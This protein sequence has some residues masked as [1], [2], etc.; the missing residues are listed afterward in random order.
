[1]AQMALAVSDGG[2]A[3]AYRYFS[4]HGCVF[5]DGSQRLVF[6]GGT[7]VG[8]YDVEDKASR[9]VLLVKLS[10]DSKAHLGRLAWAFELSEEQL[11]RLRRR[12]EA[13]GLSSLVEIKHGGRQRV[14]TPT[15]RRKLYKLFDAGASIDTAHARINKCISRT[16][17]GRVRKVWAGQREHAD[18]VEGKAQQ[19]GTSEPAPVGLRLV[20]PAPAQP[21][22]SAEVAE[23]VACE[24]SPDAVGHSAS[25]AETGRQP[26][27]KAEQLAT[28]RGLPAP[29]S[30]HE[31]EEVATDVAIGSGK[32]YVQHA[33][34]LIML[35]LLNA[36]GLYR[37]AESLRQSA[38]AAGEIE[39]RYLGQTALRVAL[40]ATIIALTI[41]QKCVEGVRRIAT[42]SA[43]AL[44][45]I[46]L[47]VPTPQ[48]V[49]QVVG[50]FAQAR[51]QLLHCAVS[52]ALID[53]AGREPE[54]RA[55]FY[56]DNHL[57]PY[58]GR[59][60]LR[61][62]WRMQDKRVRPGAADY[63]VHDQ[64]GR[65]LLRMGSPSHE[66]MTQQLVPIGRLLRA[67]L[68][69]AGAE[70]TRVTLVF[71]RAGAFPSQL[72]QLRDAGFEFVTYERRPYARLLASE[73]DQ[74]LQLGGEVIRYCEPHQKNLGKGRG[75]IRRIHL[76]MP[77]GEQVNVLAI[78]T[79]PAEDLI[80]ALL[81]RWALQENQFKYGVE[82]L[83]IN[84]LDGRR[85]EL[86]PADEVIPNPARRR[87]LNA[88]AIARKLEGEALRQLA[89]LPPDD[90]RRERWEQELRRSRKQQQDLEAQRPE[91]PERIRVGDSE[92]AGRLSRHRDDYKLVIDTLRVVI[93]NIIA[94]LATTL[95]PH[96]S[97]AAEA[98]KTLDNLL[99]AP[100]VVRVNRNRIDVNL[101]PAATR[102]ERAAF[103][104]L[105]KPI[106]ARKLALPGDPARRPVRFEVHIE[107][108]RQL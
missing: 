82:R 79:A 68:D 57:R 6:V 87:L 94:D 69:H 58:T 21:E 83:G 108:D 74:E 71:D 9:N 7:L 29:P 30:L 44:L 52:F 41:G 62:G 67:G 105:L 22:P 101:L 39:C 91:V 56:A 15:L 1:M 17:V 92:L 73:F 85:V 70:R 96:L 53:E 84:Q 97:R 50:R 23:A 33:G 72:A 47:A 106:N 45:R 66:P 81:A 46:L 61:K 86:V 18:G 55:W 90:R 65:P 76:L 19:V 31:A 103:A 89:H 104:N 36:L 63:W 64:D 75:R 26:P 77:D 88:L 100:A 4:A 95:G 28:A 43:Q 24:A 38:I 107:G 14:V 54:P 34:S 8:S 93:A 35:A 5:K 2:S 20:S 42:P 40:D 3:S 25:H 98:K 11:R 60:T 12:Y 80:K 37:W 32:Q 49:R 48:W 102:R 51:G 16:M 59:H 13:H 10:E 27:P 78:S 99:A